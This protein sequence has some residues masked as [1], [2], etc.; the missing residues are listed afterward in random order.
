MPPPPASE[1][2]S[3]M[4]DASTL[5]HHFVL[6]PPEI[7]LKIWDA[8]LESE[9]ETRFLWYYGMG[10]IF[11]PLQ[12]DDRAVIFPHKELRSNLLVVNHES[13]DQALRFYHVKLR[14]HRCPPDL[15]WKMSQRP[16][17][18]MDEAMNELP[19]S[20]SGL[21][22]IRPEQDTVLYNMKI[23]SHED[24]PVSHLVG[25]N[26]D[27]S[28]TIREK[29]RHVWFVVGW[30]SRFSSRLALA[31]E[32]WSAHSRYYFGK[33]LPFLTRH[34]PQ[35]VSVTRIQD[36]WILCTGL[37]VERMLE[38]GLSHVLKQWDIIVLE[39]NEE[40]DYARRSK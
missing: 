20:P 22:Y 23:D 15:K 24:W 28:A 29:F 27:I 34:F 5:F 3:W 32:E 12:F 40:E 6:L 11:S 38:K 33:L 17:E 9:T 31:S 13:R 1:Q 19:E 36:S 21:V 2:V 18:A 8:A 7:R 26:A 4:Q 25:I 35:L 37:V 16:R 14:V 30:F 39:D 10:G